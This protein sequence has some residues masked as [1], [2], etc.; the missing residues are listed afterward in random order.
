MSREVLAPLRLELWT[1]ESYQMELG[2]VLRSSAELP[3][4]PMASLTQ[5]PMGRQ[6]L[7]SSILMRR[8][9][10]GHTTSV[11]WRMQE[12]RW[13]GRS[14]RHSLLPSKLFSLP[15]PSLSFP[16]VTHIGSAPAACSVTPCLDYGFSFLGINLTGSFTFFLH[17]W[18][19]AKSKVLGTKSWAGLVCRAWGVA[20]PTYLQN[21]W[22]SIAVLRWTS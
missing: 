11:R 7:E 2:T 20:S 22:G 3:L 21:L 4:A 16:E 6:N 9:G 1:V 14:Y 8:M 15:G 18:C 12:E 5:L 17:H 13:E 10:C 19:V